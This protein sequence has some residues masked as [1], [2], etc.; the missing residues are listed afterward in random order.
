MANKQQ[1]IIFL[2][3]HGQQNTMIQHFASVVALAFSG[4]QQEKSLKIP[5][6]TCTRPGA[7]TKDNQSWTTEI[8]DF[9][10]QQW[11]QLWDIRNQDRHGWDLATKHQALAQQVERELTLFYD[12]EA[13]VP[14][15]MQWIFDTPIQVR[16]Q[17][18][19]Y[20][21]RQWLNTWFPLVQEALYP[22]ADPNNPENHPYTTA[23]ETG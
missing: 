19:T 23:L 2:V 15:H 8:I 3:G 13:Q 22:E 14:Q 16:R 11:K 9:I 12:C 10:F 5:T 7:N 1:S 4:L 6:E 17:W 20:A 21:M 18:P